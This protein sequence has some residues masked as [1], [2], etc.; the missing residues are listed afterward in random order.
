MTVQ[1]YF[2]VNEDEL[3]ELGIDPETSEGKAKLKQ[4]LLDAADVVVNGDLNV[5]PYHMTNADREIAGKL[6]QGEA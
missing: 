5:L 1:L 6:L 4:V 2:S 3:R